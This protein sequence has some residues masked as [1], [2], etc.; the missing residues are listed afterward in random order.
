MKVRVLA[1]AVQDM[2]TGKLY[3]KGKIIDL[4]N[5]RAY[6]AIKKGYVEEV[7]NNVRTGKTDAPNSN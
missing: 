5:E 4:P 2:V 1:K 6:K 3:A 7:K